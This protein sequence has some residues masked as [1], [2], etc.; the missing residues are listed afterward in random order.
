MA[1]KDRILFSAQSSEGEKYTK[2]NVQ[3]TSAA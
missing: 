1:M 3:H 2:N